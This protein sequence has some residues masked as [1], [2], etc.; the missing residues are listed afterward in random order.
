MNDIEHLD[1]NNSEEVFSFNFKKTHFLFLLNLI[2]FAIGLTTGYII[3]GRSSLPLTEQIDTQ[4]Q[5]TQEQLPVPPSS[6]TE[7]IA[8]RYDVPADDDPFL[9]DE[10]APIT[11]IEFSDFECPYCTRFHVETFPQLMEKYGDQI[12]FVYRDFPL[13]SIHPEAFPSAE[14]AN[15]AKEQEKYWEFHGKLFDGGPS[16]LSSEMYLI[17]AE[18]IGLNMESFQECVEEHRYQREVQVDFDYAVSLGVNS[19]P[20]FFINGLPLIGAQP[21]EVFEQIILAELAGEIQ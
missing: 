6:P 9:G 16:N 19:T 11:I 20:T 5:V 10:N 17:Y 13:S 7:Q 1:K 8:V 3:W 18:E 2:I 21:F 14:A 12:K 15:C 4:S